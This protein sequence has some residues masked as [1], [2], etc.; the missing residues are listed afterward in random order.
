MTSFMWDQSFKL[1]PDQNIAL[2]FDQ[3]L[4]ANDD[5]LRL[6]KITE[7]IK[8]V[9]QKL[10]QATT[11]SSSKLL[12]Q[13]KLYFTNL[14]VMCLYPFQKSNIESLISAFFEYFQDF[15]FIS[16]FFEATSDISMLQETSTQSLKQRITMLQRFNKYLSIKIQSKPKD[17]H[18]GQQFSQAVSSEIVTI[19]LF[20]VN[21]LK[22]FFELA[23]NLQLDFQLYCLM[24]K[25]YIQNTTNQKLLEKVM[26]CFQ[27]LRFTIFDKCSWVNQFSEEIIIC[28]NIWFIA[29][30]FKNT[31]KLF[32]SY[33]KYKIVVIEEDSDT[34]IVSQTQITVTQQ[35]NKRRS[36]VS[37]EQD[38][39]LYIQNL[40]CKQDPDQPL[41][42]NSV[43]E[44]IENIDIL[45]QFVLDPTQI[46]IA[47]LWNE[48]FPKLPDIIDN[49]KNIFK[50]KSTN[51]LSKYQVFRSYRAL[52]ILT[53]IENFK[54]L[55]GQ[56]SQ[57]FAKTFSF[58]NINLYDETKNINLY[59][60]A[61]MIKFLITLQPKFCIKQLIEQKIFPKLLEL[62]Y[63]PQVNQLLTEMINFNEDIVKL[64]I[65]YL[66]QLWSYLHSFHFL[67]LLSNYSFDAQLV[68]DI[69][70]P[71]QTAYNE[72]FQVIKA[73]SIFDPQRMQK[74]LLKQETL[75]IQEMNAMQSKNDYDNLEVF[76][77]EKQEKLKRAEDDQFKRQSSISI[78]QS[79]SKV[80]QVQKRKS[81]NFY[82]PKISSNTSCQDCDDNKINSGNI[83]TSPLMRKRNQNSQHQGKNKMKTEQ[84]TELYSNDG[85]SSSKLVQIYPTTKSVIF[86]SDFEKE[87]SQFNK[88][89]I[90]ELHLKMLLHLFDQLIVYA[91]K[92]QE[93]QK[94]QPKTQI[95]NVDKFAELI[96]T[97]KNIY[98]LFKVFLYSI[99]EIPHN[100][101]SMSVECGLLLHKLYIKVKT[102]QIFDNY[103]EMLKNQFQLVID[104]L[105]KCIVQL[106]S[107]KQKLD[108]SSFAFKQYILVS[109]MT[110]GL[111][112]YDRQN[113]MIK[114]SNRHHAPYYYHLVF[115]QLGRIQFIEQTF[116]KFIY[117]IF[118]QELLCLILSNII[119]KLGLVSSLYNAYTKFYQNEIKDTSYVEGI[120]FYILLINYIIRNAIKVRNLSDLQSA[121]I[122]LDSWQQLE[123]AQP[124]ENPMA[125]RNADQL[126]NVEQPK[127]VEKVVP[128]KNEERNMKLIKTK[129]QLNQKVNS[130]MS[131]QKKISEP[132]AGLNAQTSR[133]EQS[134]RKLI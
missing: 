37:S 129:T 83:K 86:L 76:Q 79:N 55:L 111:Q 58:I 7:G 67:Q 21:Y 32:P 4:N 9:T 107:I 90:S 132:N 110:N 75:D 103:K 71:D 87:K 36:Y 13:R 8:Y 54:N 3:A 49:E 120:F 25:H 42:H 105:V 130:L 122:I 10:P 50:Y 95:F 34:E 48:N 26:D 22:K 94:R 62:S 66:E 115:R 44:E 80:H 100:P 15:R 102:I 5:Y 93:L 65:Y 57:I 14:I 96:I 89:S 12:F 45:I 121:L 101:N 88:N 131:L 124:F 82:L 40:C 108:S 2:V 72:I 118:C 19:K 69:P 29:L 113:Y 31:P 104:Y 133:P 63:N 134:Q 20:T 117:H 116:T 112:L 28:N 99:L 91:E 70:T 109:L 60:L 78:N 125:L 39:S 33:S 74:K 6:L 73:L 17:G 119:F 126:I 92:Q 123:Q 64:G 85:F 52:Q 77:N 27:D 61:V 35:Q 56:Y 114:K 16:C 18:D 51:N 128:K 24:F 23:N 30:V 106:N 84:D 43:F 53:N 46:S 68:V 81:N 1:V 127:Q 59:H 41:Q 47:S 97:E 38:P 11:F 98:S